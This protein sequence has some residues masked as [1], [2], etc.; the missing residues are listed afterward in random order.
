MFTTNPDQYT[1]RVEAG[2]APD[3][4][5]TETPFKV[6]YASFIVTG[7]QRLQSCP[8]GYGLHLETLK[9]LISRGLPVDSSDIAGLTPLF[10]AVTGQV[11]RLDLARILL[12]AGAN[13]DFQ[14]RYGEVA[15]FGAFQ[16]NFTTAIDLLM[17]FGA[18]LDI[19]EADGI[20]PMKF[21]LSCGPQVT[22]TVTRWINKRRGEEA[23]LAEK[24]C[25]EC[26]RSDVSLKNCSKCHAA[27]YCTVECQ[28]TSMF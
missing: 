4:E 11:L 7:A 8:P 17:E 19:A 16:R 3:L 1:Q 26:G 22:A 23:P 13:V 28:R 20:T 27:R 5:G 9:Y 15:L 12:E 21:F 2:D 10:H 25:G 18:S 24:R 6:G 14:N